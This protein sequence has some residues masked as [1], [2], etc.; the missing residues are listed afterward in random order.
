MPNHTYEMRKLYFQQ[1]QYSAEKQD[2]K[3]NKSP[4]FQ[5]PDNGYFKSLKP[6][7][8][9]LQT[10]LQ[11]EDS[12]KQQTI[13][14]KIFGNEIKQQYSSLKHITNLLRERSQ[15]HEKHIKEINSRDM[16]V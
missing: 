14:E 12:C 11:S 3:Y 6:D 9:L 8:E 10:A 7:I 4:L 13:S 15:L 5:W 16:Q 1:S 2:D